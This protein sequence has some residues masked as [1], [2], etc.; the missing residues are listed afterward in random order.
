MPKRLRFMRACRFPTSTMIDRAAFDDDA[1]TLSISFRHS[2]KYVY[3][4]VPDSVF[5]ALCKAASAG[6]FFNDHIKG[7]FRFRRAPERR[8][9]GPNAET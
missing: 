5:E 7:R 6:T 3:Y 2:T 8:R 4:D 1:G 9:Y